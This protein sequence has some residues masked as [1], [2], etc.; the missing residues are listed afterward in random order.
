MNRG[1]PQS[2]CSMSAFKHVVSRGGGSVG[3]LVCNIGCHSSGAWSC[4]MWFSLETAGPC[5]CV[6]SLEPAA[7]FIHGRRGI[8]CRFARHDGC[9][10]VAA[11]CRHRARGSTAEV[12]VVAGL[13]LVGDWLN[14]HWLV[15]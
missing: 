5:A 8:V 10:E 15:M 11:A 3:V 13:W 6:A 1:S 9:N 4:R 2:Q 7:A 12:P 14:L